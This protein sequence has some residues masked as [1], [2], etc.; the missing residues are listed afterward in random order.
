MNRLGMT[1]VLA[2][3]LGCRDGAPSSASPNAFADGAVAFA[4][5]VIDAAWPR[6]SLSIESAAVI[7]DTLR[8]TLRFGGGCRPHRIGLLLG[9][10]FM[11]SYPV[12]VH[13]RLAHDAAGD[14]CKALLTRTRDFDL[15]P[16]R[17]RYR[18]SYGAGAAV[19]ILNLA[20]YRGSVRYAFD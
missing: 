6:D 14:M 15:T 18:A 13:A 7:G 16:L 2:V 8:L 1:V 17:R 11:E 12:Q 5:N 4:D 9:N 20:G 10:V 19:V 3:L